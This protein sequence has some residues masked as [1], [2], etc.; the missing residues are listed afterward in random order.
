MDVDYDAVTQEIKRLSLLLYGGRSAPRLG[1]YDTE[2]DKAIPRAQT[3]IKSYDLPFIAESWEK[4]VDDLTGLKIRRK[5]NATRK[6]VA[7][8]GETEIDPVPEAAKQTREEERNRG[9]TVC[10]VRTVDR[11]TYYMVR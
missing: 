6:G 4:I 8:W 9:L 5:S 2:R 11:S 1:V 3:I 7:T 10:R